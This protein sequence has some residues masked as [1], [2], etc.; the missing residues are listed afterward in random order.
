MIAAKKRVESFVSA[1]DSYLT[2][3]DQD[4][5]SRRAFADPPWSKEIDHD[6]VVRHTNTHNQMVD[7]ETDVAGRFNAALKNFQDAHPK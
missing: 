5:K 1:G 6:E 7:D 4:L 2:C 3:L